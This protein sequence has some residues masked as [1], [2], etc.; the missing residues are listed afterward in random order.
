MRAD[1]QAVS[2]YVPVRDRHWD[3]NGL[4]GRGDLAHYRFVDLS[5]SMERYARCLLPNQRVVNG[6]IEL[7][8]GNYP[9]F[10]VVHVRRN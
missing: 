4:P 7:D 2:Q 9:R 5:Q 8:V 1:L 10:P 6:R 3:D